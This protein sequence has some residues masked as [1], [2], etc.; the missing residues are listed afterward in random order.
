MTRLAPIA[1]SVFKRPE[2]T[3]GSTELL[4]TPERASVLQYYFL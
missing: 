1:L 4:L 2:E 3:A